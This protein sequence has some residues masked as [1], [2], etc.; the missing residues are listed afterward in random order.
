MSWTPLLTSPA[1]PGCPCVNPGSSY[2][3]CAYLACIYR[4]A[5]DQPSPAAVAGGWPAARPNPRPIAQNYFPA[6]GGCGRC[7]RFGGV[8]AL[9]HLPT[10]RPGAPRRRGAARPPRLVYDGRGCR[11]TGQKWDGFCSP[12]R[13]PAAV[14]QG[15]R[16]LR[17]RR[18]AGGHRQAAARSSGR[19]ARAASWAG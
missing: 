17:G 3:C 15:Q 14:G 10:Q 13:R 11:G 2:S 6:A 4:T 5:H 19:E 8:A 16:T 18:H 7:L 9:P 12:S 1:L